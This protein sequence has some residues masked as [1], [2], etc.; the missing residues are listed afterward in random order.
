MTLTA[1]SGDDELLS[2]FFRARSQFRALGYTVFWATSDPSE[3]GVPQ[4]RTR[5]Y[6]WMFFSGGCAWFVYAEHSVVQVAIAALFKPHDGGPLFEVQDFALPDMAASQ[7]YVAT[8]FADVKDMAKWPEQ[9]STF[10]HQYGVN[11]PVTDGAYNL[12]PSVLAAVFPHVSFLPDRELDML[13]TM[14]KIHCKP[15]GSGR[16]ASGR[17]LFLNLSQAMVREPLTAGLLGCITPG[18]KFMDL[19]AGE[20]LHGSTLMRLQLIVDSID[21][22]LDLGCVPERMLCDLSGNA[23]SGLSF[24]LAVVAAFCTSGTAPRFRISRMRRAANDPEVQLVEQESKRH[25]ADSA[26]GALLSLA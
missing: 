2:N 22:Q 3:H 14:D 6:Y 26:L 16:D 25:T 23:C 8:S 20:I 11:Y 4:R 15:S 21:F 13:K 10:A 5:L 24:G 17:K 1:G 7:R 12:A 9:H 19:E 18:A